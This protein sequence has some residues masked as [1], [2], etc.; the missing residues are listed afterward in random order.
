[1][2]KTVSKLEQHTAI[3]AQTEE[4]I[5][6]TLRRITDPLTRAWKP[7]ENAKKVVMKFN[8]MKPPER[9]IYYE[10]RRRELVDDATCRAVL[11]LIKEHTT[12][13]LVATDTKPLY[14]RAPDASEFQL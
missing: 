7:I 10:G 12:A 2:E 13:Q 9:I 14:P 5:Y 6:Q 4:E 3:I 1:M 11:R 8:M